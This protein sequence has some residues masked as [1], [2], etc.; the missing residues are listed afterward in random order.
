[1][2]LEQD[3]ANLPTF[4]KNLRAADAGVRYWAIVGCFNL[5]QSNNLNMRVIR[6]SLDDTSHHVRIMA[7]WILYRD[8]D[9]QAAQ[10][11]WNELLSESS[12]ASLKI[13]NIVD[14]IGDGVEPYAAAMKSCT[15]SHQGYVARMQ[16]YLGTK[17]AAPQKARKKK[18]R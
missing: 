10:R 2:A 15:F 16:D 14:W 11:C 12:Y 17:P 13:F 6:T 9:K 5:Q 7:A 4:Y 3:A 1:M 18:K 8:G